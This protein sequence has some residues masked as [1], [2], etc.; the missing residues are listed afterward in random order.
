VPIALA[1]GDQGGSLLQTKKQLLKASLRY[2]LVWFC[3]TSKLIN[4]PLTT[5]T[6]QS[7]REFH[8]LVPFHVG[9]LLDSSGL[10]I[11]ASKVW[12]ARFLCLCRMNGDTA[13]S[14]RKQ[15][16]RKHNPNWRSHLPHC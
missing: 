10:I 16:H 14:R 5:I 13:T 7:R 1:R 4:F 6:S 3:Y 15:H 8:I 12:F 11:G 9:C 2:N